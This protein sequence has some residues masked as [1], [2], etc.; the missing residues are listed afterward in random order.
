MTT[1][2]TRMG[3][4]RYS[5]T[6]PPMRRTMRNYADLSRRGKKRNSTFGSN[7]TIVSDSPRV[8]TVPAKFA[9]KKGART[10]MQKGIAFVKTRR[11]NHSKE[12]RLYQIGPEG[13][14]LGE[15]LQEYRRILSGFPERGERAGTD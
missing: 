7:Q 11:G 9:A 13:I 15:S 8:P 10:P 4:A 6:M 1:T 2:N 14:V 5:L 3:Q 12:L